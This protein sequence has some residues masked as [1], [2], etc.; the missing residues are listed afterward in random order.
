MK[1]TSNEDMCVSGKGQKK[2]RRH[3]RESGNPCVTVGGMKMDPRMR[4]DDEVSRDGEALYHRHSR[5]G[6]N[7][8]VT[9]AGMKMDPRMREDDEVWRDGEASRDAETSDSRG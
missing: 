5:E 3:S 1:I 7:P 4:E 8:C 6:G 2:L 9:V